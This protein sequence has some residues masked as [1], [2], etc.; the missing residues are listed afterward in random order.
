[1]MIH[2]PEYAPVKN[3]P[4]AARCGQKQRELMQGYGVAVPAGSD[5]LSAGC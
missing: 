1:M 4:E 2:S 3:F 5:E